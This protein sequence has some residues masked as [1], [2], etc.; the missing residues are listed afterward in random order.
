MDLK[1][2]IM[3]RRW[4]SNLQSWL[5][6]L[7]ALQIFLIPY[8]EINA[9]HELCFYSSVLLFIILLTSK[10]EMISLKTPLSIPIGLFVLWCIIGLFFARNLPNS[11]HDIYAHLI[12]YLFISYLT[13][14]FLADRKYITPLI[15]GIIISTTLFAAGN[16]INYYMILGNPISKKLLAHIAVE[17]PTNIIAIIT[18]FSTGLCIYLITQSASWHHKTILSSC[19]TVLMIT[20]LATQSRSA[21]LAMFMVLIMAFRKNKK[22]ILSLGIVMVLFIAFMP[23]KNRLSPDAVLDKLRK[24]DRINIWYNYWEIIKDHKVFGVGFG[25]QTFYDDAFMRK[26][27]D[28]VPVAFRNV[29]VYHAPHN[30]IVDTAA[31]TGLIGLIFFLSILITFV[32]MT[33]WI[34][35]RSKDHFSRHWASCLLAVFTGLFIQG[36]FENTLS[37]PPAVILYVIFALATILWTMSRPGMASPTNSAKL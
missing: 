28:R 26:Y 35:C 4:P 29:D 33:L 3:N 9:V 15:W 36:L 14:H 27:N 34:I 18:L 24:D 31:R 19:L 6:V 8:P 22:V 1:E 37:G 25:M 13:M 20:T 30:S 23:V 10:K 11:I 5:R 7:I 21:L 16:M 2:F 12:K 17:I 32:Y